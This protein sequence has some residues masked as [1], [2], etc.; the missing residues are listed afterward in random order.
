MQSLNSPEHQCIFVRLSGFVTAETLLLRRRCLSISR[1]TSPKSLMSSSR[2]PRRPL[3]ATA[4]VGPVGSRFVRSPAP[5]LSPEPPAGASSSKAEIKK[6]L[7][8]WTPRLL[9]YYGALDLGGPDCQFGDLHHIHP[10]LQKENFLCTDFEYASVRRALCLASAFLYEPVA[11]VYWYSLVFGPRKRVPH[12]VETPNSGARDAT[13]SPWSSFSAVSVGPGEMAQLNTFWE[14]L[15]PTIK[16]E[17]IDE[18]VVPGDPCSAITN[19]ENWDPARGQQGPLLGN[20]RGARVGISQRFPDFL[21]SLQA[22]TLP[23]D[24]IAYALREDHILAMTVL[25]ELAHAIHIVRM[26]SA[27]A[28]AE[29]FFEDMREAE[30]GFAWEQIVINGRLDVIIQRGLSSARMGLYFFTWP[31][32]FPVQDQL[33]LS[34]HPLSDDDPL[35]RRFGRRLWNTSYLVMMKYIQELAFRHTWRDIARHGPQGL[36]MEKLV[37]RRFGVFNAN[38]R[39]AAQSSGGDSLS[40]GS[41]GDGTDRL[42]VRDELLRR[43]RRRRI[44]RRSAASMNDES[45]APYKRRLLGSGLSG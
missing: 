5:S 3:R 26:K 12:I 10:L 42:V 43:S 15:Q 22:G 30:V 37:G 33:F 6:T 16:F 45:E 44:S 8:G 21:G 40:W 11:S 19:S 17:F 14:Q 28:E 35:F 32:T 4:H 38:T 29:P 25:H 27:E 34:K 39:A 36:K 2:Y 13:E 9:V 18:G 1:D 23:S 31:D 41:S 20:R 24:E 7:R